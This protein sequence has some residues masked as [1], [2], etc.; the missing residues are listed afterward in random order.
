MKSPVESETLGIASTWFSRHYDSCCIS[1]H[2]HSDI[3]FRLMKTSEL[4]LQVIIN[5]NL[6]HFLRGSK[7][8]K[9]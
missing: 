9:V 5:I 4:S 1:E 2:Q 3:E 6:F 8:S 7:S